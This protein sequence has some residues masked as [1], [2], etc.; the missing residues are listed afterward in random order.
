MTANVTATYF[1]FLQRV[2]SKEIKEL[3]ELKRDCFLGRIGTD[4]RSVSKKEVEL[5]ELWLFNRAREILDINKHFE[6]ADELGQNGFNTLPEFF[7]A[8]IGSA[9]R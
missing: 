7:R 1:T 9:K 8:A 5:F 4:G 3:K 6:V 2:L